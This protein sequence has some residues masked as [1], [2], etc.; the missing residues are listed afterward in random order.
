LLK[1]G[2]M[3]KKTFII[4]LVAAIVIS[5]A[6]GFYAGRYFERVSIRNTFQNTRGDFQGRG[7]N[8]IRRSGS[9]PGAIPAATQP[10]Q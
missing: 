3:D 9:V 8:G 4:S 5:L 6:L 1:G 7:A 10:A 2:F